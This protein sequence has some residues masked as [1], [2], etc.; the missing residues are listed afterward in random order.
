L[1][2]PPH[3]ESTG[4]N[5]QVHD[6]CGKGYLIQVPASWREL[7]ARGQKL[8]RLG[9]PPAEIR[10]RLGISTSRWGEIPLACSQRVVAFEVA[11]DDDAAD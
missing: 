7:H 6:L 8:L 11:E 2:V 9:T 1:L 5:S 3:V 10:R 4:T